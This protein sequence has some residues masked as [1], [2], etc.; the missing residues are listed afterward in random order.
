MHYYLLNDTTNINFYHRFRRWK[1]SV[2]KDKIKKEKNPTE[3]RN[4]DQEPMKNNEDSN[5]KNSRNKK[6]RIS[7]IYKAELE[8][9]TSALLF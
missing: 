5:S 8:G 1:S 3:L 2:L 9:Q 4:T 6:I 7:T